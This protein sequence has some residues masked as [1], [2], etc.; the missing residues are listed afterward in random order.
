MAARS[1][2]QALSSL[3]AGIEGSNPVEGMGVRLLCLLCVAQ[4]G[5]SAT[6]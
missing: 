1:K 2:T 6:S 3:M 5:A 4:I